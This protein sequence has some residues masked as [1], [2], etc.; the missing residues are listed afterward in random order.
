MH[1]LWHNQLNFMLQMIKINC[2]PP[3][4]L[5]PNSLTYADTIQ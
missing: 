3:V 5:I 2:Y 4:Q 1:E